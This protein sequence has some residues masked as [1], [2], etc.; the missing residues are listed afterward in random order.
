MMM[1]LAH[2]YGEPVTIQEVSDRFGVSKNH[3]V[4]ETLPPVDQFRLD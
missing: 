4:K 3:M 2:R 1:Y